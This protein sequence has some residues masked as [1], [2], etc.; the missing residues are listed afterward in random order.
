MTYRQNEAWQAMDE[1]ERNALRKLV[2]CAKPEERGMA[3]T[4]VKALALYRYRKARKAQKNRDTDRKAR[5]LVGARVPR[6][7]YQAIKEAAYRNGQSM[8]AFIREALYRAAQEQEPG[9]GPRG[10]TASELTERWCF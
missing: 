9:R 1:R 8:Y 5:V 6:S 3:Q 7:E 4:V 2:E 10:H